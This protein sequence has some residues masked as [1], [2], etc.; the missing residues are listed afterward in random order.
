MQLIDQIEKNQ[1]EEIG[2]KKG[3][4]EGYD[5]SR[6]LMQIKPAT[7]LMQFIIFQTISLFKT[8]NKTRIVF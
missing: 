1:P 7:D 8:R 5:W 3:C 6:Y 2:K 4:E